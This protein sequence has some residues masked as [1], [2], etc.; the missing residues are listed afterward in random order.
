MGHKITCISVEDADNSNIYEERMKIRIDKTN[1][2]QNSIRRTSVHY[3][4]IERYLMPYYL[5][6]ALKQNLI[7]NKPDIIHCRSYMPLSAAIMAKKKFEIPLLF[8][9]RGFWIDQRIESHQWDTK[10]FTHK[11]IINHFRKL[12]NIAF[13]TSDRIVVLTQEAKQYIENHTFYNGA[14]IDVIPCSVD[15]TKF[16]FDHSRRDRL[17]SE[18]GFKKKDIVM[19]YLGSDGHLYRTDVIF[20]LYEKLKKQNIKIKLLFVGNHSVNSLINKSHN[21]GINIERSDIVSTIAQHKQVPELL[22]AADFG[23]FFI[24]QSFSSLG[25]SATKICEY[26]S[27]GLPVITNQGIGDIQKIII[28]GRNGLILKDFS[29]ESISKTAEKTLKTDFMPREEIAQISKDIFNIE[30]AI[31]IYSNIYNDITSQKKCEGSL[32]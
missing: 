9:T 25:V 23:L 27:C 16:K 11:K 24:I 5:K 22:N 15:Q 18:L 17:R 7:K 29:E 8:D 14:P 26:L 1:L 10:K 28:D 19:T 32:F 3:R 13:S 12:E 4:A 6:M 2:V 21:M 31:T 20:K 30:N